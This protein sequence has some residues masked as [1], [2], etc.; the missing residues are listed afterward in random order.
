MS[1]N[2]LAYSI[3]EAYEKQYDNAFVR[4]VKH[5]ISTFRALLIRR[6]IERDG[7]VSNHFTQTIDC[8]ELEKSSFTEC[9]GLVLPVECQV[10]R[11]KNTIPSPVRLKKDIPFVFVGGLTGEYN[12]SYKPIGAIK[13]AMLGKY[14][15]SIPFYTYANNRIY[16]YNKSTRRIM[17]KGIF[18][19]PS[20]IS[21][22]TNCNNVPCYTD[23]DEYPISA[24]MAALVEEA[25]LSDI[26][27]FSKLNV[28]H[29]DEGEVDKSENVQG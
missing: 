7:V 29:E 9:C 20:K 24:D 1:L 22:I 10:L 16:V 27:K 3:A 28:T 23:E 13:Y 12:M 4:V 8:I 17:V 5:K 15:K 26:A 14:T 19:D 18:E 2:E 11:T 21:A 25:V 6:S